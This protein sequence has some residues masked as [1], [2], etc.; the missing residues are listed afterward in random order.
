MAVCDN[1]VPNPFNLLVFNVAGL[2]GGQANGFTYF[3]NNS[4]ILTNGFCVLPSPFEASTVAHGFLLDH[5]VL[6]VNGV[7]VGDQGNNAA[8]LSQ[9]A[10]DRA[11]AFLGTLAVQP[12][13]DT[14]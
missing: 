4:T 8:I 1:V 11:A 12:A 13:N 7:Q 9:H 10:R 2:L 14:L 3:R 6:A 5:G